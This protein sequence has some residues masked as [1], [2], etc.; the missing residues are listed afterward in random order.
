MGARNSAATPVRNSFFTSDFQSL[1]VLNP[2]PCLLLAFAH[3]ELR[4]TKRKNSGSKTSILPML[5]GA[6]L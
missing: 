6:P 5:V 2:E 3:S 1:Y 4:S